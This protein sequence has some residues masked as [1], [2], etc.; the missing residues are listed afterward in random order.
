MNAVMKAPIPDHVREKVRHYLPGLTVVERKGMICPAGGLAASL[1]PDLIAS[2]VEITALLDNNTAKHGTTIEGLPVLPLSSIENELPDF[3]LVATISFRTELLAQLQ[4]LEHRFGFRIIDLCDSPTAPCALPNMAS[5]RALQQ[6]FQ[7]LDTLYAIECRDQID[8]ILSNPKYDNPLRL[9]KC[10]YSCYSQHDEDGIIQ[11]IIRRLG[12]GPRTF[13]EFGVGDGLENNTLLL[14]KQGWNG[15]WIDGSPENAAAIRNRFETYIEAGTLQFVENMITRENINELIGKHFVG[16]IGLLSVDIDG[17]DYYVW[18]AIDAISP[19][20]VVIEYNGKF[21][22]PIKWSI[23]YDPD[24]RWDFSDYQGASLAA[25]A[26]LGCRKNF[27]L[28]GCN[29]NGTNA[30]FVRQDLLNGQFLES[31]DPMD[32]YHPTRYYLMEG[33]RH[34]S[35]HRRDPR[36]GRFF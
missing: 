36:A 25:L 19:R 26:E 3:I 12:N 1:L 28:V 34:M 35:G 33:F 16:E 18:E 21:P 24:H 17:N 6:V 13:V 30:F 9:D 15:L 5:D 31:Q 7:R 4:S 23:S 29:I 22:P 27:Q 2:G 20:I 10:G 8:R 11:E 32:Y 14:L